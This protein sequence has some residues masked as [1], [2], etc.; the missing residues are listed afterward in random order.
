MSM[1]PARRCFD[2]GI[3]VGDIDKSLGFY[4]GLLGLEKLEEFDVPFG[5][6]HRLRF[7]DSFVKLVDPKEKPGPV[8]SGLTRALGFRYLTFPVTNL[9]EVC[10]ACEAGGA[11][12]ELAKRELMPGVFVAMFLDPDGN[13]VELVERR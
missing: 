2:I 13:V 9:D 3:L 1:K 12:V 6:M 5:R 10:A 7:G 8:I 4:Q 11:R